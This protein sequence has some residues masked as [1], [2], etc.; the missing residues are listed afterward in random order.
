MVSVSQLSPHSFLC[1]A[2]A[3]DGNS[4]YS[5]LRNKAVLTGDSGKNVYRG[6]AWRYNSNG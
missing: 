3:G 1:C 2:R 5:L 6:L 4:A